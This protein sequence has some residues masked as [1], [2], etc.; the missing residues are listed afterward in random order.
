MKLLVP[1]VWPK[2]WLG[3]RVNLI[4]FKGWSREG[5]GGVHLL[6]LFS[7]P[8]SLITWKQSEWNVLLVQNHIMDS[9]HEGIYS[10][11][12]EGFPCGLVVKSL[13]TNAADTREADL[14]PGL[15][16]SQ[17]VGRGNPLQ[18]SCLDNP[19]DTG[20]LVGY[21]P[22]GHKSWTQL[23]NWAHRNANRIEL[24]PNHIWAHQ[25]LL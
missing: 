11:M 6:I 2:K 3:M 10:S 13:P 21:C 25:W 1:T 23:S 14:M 22:W 9:N 16:R 7:F 20:S 5:K 15:G 17:G 4:L 19:M 12:W 8:F 18:Y 24:L